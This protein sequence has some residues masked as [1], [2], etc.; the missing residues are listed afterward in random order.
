MTPQKPSKVSAVPG[1]AI[2]GLL[3]TGVLG[4][5]HAFLFAS[6]IGLIAAA[7]AFGWLFYVSFR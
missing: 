7:I 3:I 6:G 5:V 1:L 4:C 2:I